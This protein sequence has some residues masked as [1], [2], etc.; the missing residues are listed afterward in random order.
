MFL[1][2][3]I[4]KLLE[5]TATRGE[6]SGRIPTAGQVPRPSARL[7]THTATMSFQGLSNPSL[8]VKRQ[9]KGPAANTGPTSTS[10]SYRSHP[11]HK[12]EERKREGDIQ[13][14]L[15]RDYPNNASRIFL[16]V[17]NNRW[18]CPPTTLKHT[19]GTGQPGHQPI[20][21]MGMSRHRAAGTRVQGGTAAPRTLRKS[22]AALMPSCS[23]PSCLPQEENILGE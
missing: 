17:P 22:P 8:E 12:P 9:T 13:C 2:E 20:S 11:E 3:K 7:D 1:H 21:Q 6:E 16:P 15:T 19:R 5:V 23:V 10:V 4:Q 18:R 14:I